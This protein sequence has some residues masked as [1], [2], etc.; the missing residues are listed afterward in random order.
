MVGGTV[1]DTRDNDAQSETGPAHDSD[2]AAA[3]DRAMAEDA[4]DQAYMSI[5]E[6]AAAGKYAEAAELARNQGQ[7]ARAVE[8]YERI[9]DF[10]NAAVSAREAGD[11]A[12]ALLNAIDARNGGLV[13]ELAHALGT[14]GSDG[15]RG[16][17]RVFARRRRYGE[18]AVHAEA[19]GDL[20]T[21]LE[22]YRD[23]H[24]E[25][26]AARLLETLGREREA[27]RLLERLLTVATP[28]RERMEACLHLG[29]LLCRR[30]QYDQAA[31]HL[32]EAM[33]APE[34]R[35]MARRALIVALASM[36]LRDAA[37]E[38]L[39]A[40]RVEE[41]ELSAELETFVR[42]ERDAMMRRVAGQVAAQAAGQ[43]AGDG[44]RDGARA[45]GVEGASDTGAVVEG[46]VVEG[47]V[48]AE[49][50]IDV[51]ARGQ[52]I[53]TVGGRY[54]LD[55]LVGAGSTGRVYR[56]WDEVGG[57]EVAI[58]VFSLSRG[59]QGYE[60]FVREAH[61]AGAMRH[62]NLVEMYEFSADQDFLVMEY[63][64]GGSL[65]NRL[66]GE[67]ESPVGR[68]RAMTQPAVRRLALDMLAGLELAH[69]RGV[70][71]R[72][73][74]PAN[75]FFDAR[76]TAKLGDFGVAHLLDMGQ[77]Q[78]G[79]LIGTL[80][81]MAPEQI[82]GA[83]LTVAADL[84]ALGVT[85]Y[86]ALTGRLPF[87]GPDFVAQHLGE[88]PPAPS[89]H[90]DVVTGWDH[91]LARLL[92]KSPSD[93]YGS[94]DELRQALAELELG[95]DAHVLVLARRADK[96]PLAS[97]ATRDGG[98]GQSQADSAEL[99]NDDNLMDLLVGDDAAGEQSD[100]DAV[101]AES[102]RGEEPDEASALW[103]SGGE[104]YSFETI[105]GHTDHSQIARALDTALNRSV[106]IERYQPAPL[107]EARERRLQALARGGS[108]YLQWALAYDREAGV[109]VFE[110]P[111]G[112]LAAEVF[113][114]SSWSPRQTVRLLRRL[115][116]AVALLHA[117]GV[118]HG[119]INAQTVLVD[120]QGVPTLLTCG[121]GLAPR[122]NRAHP[123]DD[124]A[125]ILAVTAFAAGQRSQEGEG[126]E[127]K[128]EVADLAA[129]VAEAL[130]PAMSA[131]MRAQLEKLADPGTGEELYAFAEMLEVAIFSTS[132]QG[133]DR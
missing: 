115:A 20:Q 53:S 36:G 31:P 54:R 133:S 22:Y 91:V 76:G 1:R 88:T 19:A 77:T 32:Q 119:V 104:R 70:I 25:L 87:L 46:A 109:A 66:S 24:R 11:L 107:D 96:T 51:H 69:Q 35:P 102:D 114:K 82:T 86:E 103:S 73:I 6:L 108:P 67:G 18:A 121:L 5:E 94:L 50:G 17:A 89:R 112:E 15:H 99:D 131:D 38:V 113:G 78:T 13:N 62:P 49:A 125:A 126:A 7:P 90:A 71:H 12:R 130:A 33:R 122:G 81:Y 95:Q 37:R 72:D 57:Q 117:R 4:G 132:S 120:E 8:L 127:E 3:E 16:A 41:P 40:A 26:E 47:A 92:A 52:E 10:A 28:G 29:Q 97:D 42:E 118:A 111:R 39:I 64:S 60:R 105:L 61:I 116:R 30:M 27:G 110:A 123:R 48:R 85:L 56:A 106:M 80:A 58:K 75:I 65:A 93:R 84:Y 34:T 21:A 101:L 23:A 43:V 79:G 59:H 55:E 45:A 14:E 124:V 63:M 68:G 9:W 74:K 98:D 83:A 128:S 44:A 100:D 129:Q 2:L